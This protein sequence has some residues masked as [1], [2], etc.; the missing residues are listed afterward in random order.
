MKITTHDEKGIINYTEFDIIIKKQ[1]KSG[2]IIVP[3][4]LVGRRV[5]VK[6]AVID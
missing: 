2:H 1:G 5:N 3:A 4:D 6:I